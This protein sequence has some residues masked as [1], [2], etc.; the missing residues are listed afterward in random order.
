MTPIL[1]FTLPKGGRARSF[2]T[3]KVLYHLSYVGVCGSSVRVLASRRSTEYAQRHIRGAAGWC[4][5]PKTS[6]H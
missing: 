1:G 3:S 6:L 2:I 4:D 5:G